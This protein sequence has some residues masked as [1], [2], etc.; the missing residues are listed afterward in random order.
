MFVRNHTTQASVGTDEM[1]F[2]SPFSGSDDDGTEEPFD[3]QDA[4]VLEHLPDPGPFLAGHE[5]LTGDAHVR[6]HSVARECFEERGVYDVTFGYNLA[7]LNRDSRHP[8]AG[9]RY[10]E[11]SNE[12]G[13]LRVEFTPTTE[14]CP[15]GQT[16]VTAVFRALNGLSDRHDYDLVRVRIAPSH[17]A[18]ATANDVLSRLE[19]EFRETG[20]IPHPDELDDLEP[21]GS[22]VP[23]GP[24]PQAPY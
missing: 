1:Q 12:E 13:V 20:Q 9:F 24:G 23:A 18:S 19:T 4:F 2:P 11:A 21:T 3:P 5:V 6:V 8:D 14:F 7:R 16:L 17:Q 15:Q 10:A 22:D